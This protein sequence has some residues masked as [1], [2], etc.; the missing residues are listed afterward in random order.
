MK[1]VKKSVLLWYSCREMYALVTDVRA[2]P[3]F[4]PW[5]ERAEV[6]DEDERSMTAKLSLS[7]AGVRQSFTTRNEHEPDR[8]V[9]L[10]LVDGPFSTLEG[11]WQF[12]PIGTAAA[13]QAQN[14]ETPKA[15]RIEFEM[16]YAFAGRAL[17]IVVSP[18]FGRIA[19]TLVDAFVRRAE[20]V[21]G[22]R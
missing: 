2:Y 21:Y 3:E 22:P 5:C 4:L 19:N 9:T 10:A 8:Q 7:Y 12:V 17:E 13:A 11:R 14:A 1:H 16:R 20:Q 6:L 15:C 18:V